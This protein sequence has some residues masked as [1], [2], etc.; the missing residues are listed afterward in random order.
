MVLFSRLGMKTYFIVCKNDAVKTSNHSGTPTSVHKVGITVNSN[1]NVDSESA[2][3]DPATVRDGTTNQ[4]NKPLLSAEENKAPSENN[5]P[6]EVSL[7]TSSHLADGTIVSILL[8]WFI[9]PH[10]ASSFFIPSCDR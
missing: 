2:N 6:Q 4:T 7:L 1:D 9:S 3:S 8:H 5:T 10:F